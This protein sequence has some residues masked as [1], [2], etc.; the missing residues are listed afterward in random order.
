MSKSKFDYDDAPPEREP[1]RIDLWDM[2][3]ILT[4][5]LTLCIGAYFVAVFANPSAAFNLLKPGRNDPPTPTITQI[6]PPST[7]T[8]TLPG[9]SETPTL[10]L[11]PTIT[12]PATPTL[13]SLITPSVTPTPTRTPKAPFTATITY[14]DSTIIHPEAA[15]NWQGVAGTIIDANNADMLGIAVRLTG[16]YNGKT[17]NELTVSGIAPSYGKSGFEFVLGTVPVSSNGQLSIQIL[18]QAGLPLSDNIPINTYADCGKN[19]ALV[20]F[21]KNP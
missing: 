10:T 13:V 2:L 7:W 21:K 18:D 12:L 19:L 6:Q 14:I 17:K 8:P 9:P 11:L 20:K 16:F 5:L 4:L 1:A 15:C 3:S